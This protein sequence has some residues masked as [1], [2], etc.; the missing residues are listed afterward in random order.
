MYMLINAITTRYCC[1]SSS[2]KTLWRLKEMKTNNQNERISIK[3]YL[4]GFSLTPTKIKKFDL[5]YN[6]NYAA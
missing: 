2:L 5:Q 1:N 3:A 4:C 6:K